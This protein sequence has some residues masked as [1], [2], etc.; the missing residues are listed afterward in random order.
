M[1]TQ[2]RQL[3]S[4]MMKTIKKNDIDEESGVADDENNK[5]EQ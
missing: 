3:R 5:K 2:V 4:K 1:M